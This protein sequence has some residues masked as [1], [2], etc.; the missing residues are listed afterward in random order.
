[1][2]AV[3][4]KKRCLRRAEFGDAADSPYVLPY[5]PGDGYTVIQ[6]YCHDDG[7]HENQLAYDFAM[8]L[9]STVVASRSGVVI[10]PMLTDQW[11]VDAETLAKQEAIEKLKADLK[12]L[13]EENKRLS[14]AS[15][16][17]ST[18]TAA[19]IM[20]SL[21][22]FSGNRRSMLCRLRRAASS[23]AA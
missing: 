3:S 17:P 23:R 13:E 22:R 12:A 18:S 16:Q 19:R 8:P 7:S 5:P 15:S 1:M 10:E 20:A 21:R 4:L 11:F 2:V 9:G 6:S 14:A